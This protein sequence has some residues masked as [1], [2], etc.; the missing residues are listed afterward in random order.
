MENIQKITNA[1]EG[2]R[3]LC[4]EF[5]HIKHLNKNNALVYVIP[6]AT[7]KAIQENPEEFYCCSPVD[8]NA[9]YRSFLTDGFN[10]ILNEYEPTKQIITDWCSG[11]RRVA[12]FTDEEIASIADAYYVHTVPASIERVAR[13]MISEM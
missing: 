9:C 11:K 4:G 13:E 1:A 7:R 10:Y 12:E 5:Y 3:D 2:M 6:D 8:V